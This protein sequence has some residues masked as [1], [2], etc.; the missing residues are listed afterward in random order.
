M[1]K[2]ANN[3]NPPADPAA[4]LDDFD[5]EHARRPIMNY[6]YYRAILE[7]VRDR[8][9]KRDFRA[10]LA[11]LDEE[12]QTPYIPQA[13]ERYC[14]AM[15]KLV[16]GLA[17]ESADEL[18]RGMPKRELIDLAAREFPKHLHLFDYL[19]AKP[20]GFF[21]KADFDYFRF[22][23]TSAQFSNELKFNVWLLLGEIADFRGVPFDFFNANANETTRLSVG[24]PIVEDTLRP[25]YDRT[26][27]AVSETL[28]KEP[29]L[30]E[31]AN[32]VVDQILVFY[33]PALPPPGIEP[34]RL[35]R[36]L[37]DYVRNS[38]GRP[39]AKR[40]GDPEIVE[41]ILRVINRK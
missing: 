4:L 2:T 16:R 25:Y 31:M 15:A 27:A 3:Q 24:A 33:F 22:V 32:A 34:D 17:H 23:F 39:G 40:R 5:R 12:A 41:M 21:E 1:T 37:A 30:E 8:C 20:E 6:G 13:V 36:A 10:A 19:A 14:A 28:F 9:E 26:Y 38:V 29:S 11:L 18:L 35:G 7:Q